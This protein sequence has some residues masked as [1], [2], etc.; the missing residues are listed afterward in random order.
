VTGTS[1]TTVNYCGRGLVSCYK[2]IPP[3]LN[4]FPPTL[5]L[6]IP[7]SNYPLMTSVLVTSPRT[8]LPVPEPPPSLFRSMPTPNFPAEYRAG[9]R[10]RSVVGPRPLH[11]TNGLGCIDRIVPYIAIRCLAIEYPITN[12]KY[13]ACPERALATCRECCPDPPGGHQ[14]WNGLYP[15]SSVR[16]W[17]RAALASLFHRSAPVEPE[18]ASS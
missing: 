14:L 17:L 11:R 13:A 9:Q 7:T 16:Q 10:K 8:H 3:I 2:G 5:P 1:T 12:G 15:P 18:A 4:P 6:P